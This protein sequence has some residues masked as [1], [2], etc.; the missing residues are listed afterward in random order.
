M[1]KERQF[2]TSQH[3]DTA[4]EQRE[5]VRVP[6]AEEKLTTSVRA[7]ERGTLRITRRVEEEPVSE[8][9]ELHQ[10]E[11]EIEHREINE[12]AETVNLPHYDGETLVIPVYEEVPVITK[13][14]VLREEIRITKRTVDE[15]VRIE[16]PLRRDTVDVQWIDATAD[17][18][19]ERPGD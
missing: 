18:K 8:T 6:L 11:V 1:R 13:R 2:M 17:A 19:A 16:E 4:P 9:V 10:D 12:P 3:D 15:S 14:L 7:V 5:H